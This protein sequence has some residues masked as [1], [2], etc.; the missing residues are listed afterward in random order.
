M[1]GQYI[2]VSPDAFGQFRVKELNESDFWL[3]SA[4]PTALKSGKCHIIL[5]YEP[6]SVDP[7]LINIWNRLAQTI[8]GPVIAAVNT[9]ARGEIMDAFMAVGSDVDNP[10][11]DFTGFGVPTIIV[12]RNRW[13]QAFY[14]GELS[15]DAIKKWI[16]VLACKPGYKE[17]TSLFSGV[18]AVEPDVY[19]PESRIENFAY[20]TSSRDFTAQLGDN[21]RGSYQPQDQQQFDQGQFDQQQDQMTNADQ[22]MTDVGYL[23]E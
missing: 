10:L 17:R 2:A 22:G 6:T 21:P 13:P 3:A 8:A 20:P 9:S 18:A 16:S 4:T 14:N 5:F 23:S 15:Y 11:Y 1:S 12:Y 19:V 7:E